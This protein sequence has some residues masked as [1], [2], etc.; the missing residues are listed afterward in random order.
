MPWRCLMY[1]EVLPA[2]NATGGGPERF[3]V[4]L[5]SF[6]TMLDAIQSTGHVGCSIEEAL[7]IREP[8]VAISFDDGTKSQFDHAVPALVARDMTATFFVT[9]DLIGESGFMDWG[10]LRQLSSLGMSVQSHTKSHPFLSELNRAE[11]TAELRESKSVL[12][13]K[14]NQDTDQISFP[15]G[16]APR[17]RLRHLLGECGYRLVAGSRWG[18][19]R[20][21]RG[22]DHRR[23]L[24]RCTMR[25]AISA[26]EA[27]YILGSPTLLS[28][29]TCSKELALNTV[30]AAIGPSR[31][32]RWR[33]RFLDSLSERGS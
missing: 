6:E 25:G 5:E 21:R 26:A 20:G 19:N 22:L 32:A 9:T 12:D 24:Y 30:R 23:P 16:N 33:R 17:W 2:T 14:L 13:A 8:R 1:H 7:G 3:A 28:L 15:G 29:R 4:P 18:T 11:L 31:Y 27:R 10:D